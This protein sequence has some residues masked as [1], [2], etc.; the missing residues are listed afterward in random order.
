MPS[1]SNPPLQQQQIPIPP[2]FDP[3]TVDMIRRVAP[4]TMTSIERLYSLRTAVQYIVRHNIPGDIVECGVWRGGMMMAAALTLREMRA[5]DR[6][7][8]LYDTYEGMPPPT[9]ADVDHFG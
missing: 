6:K 9:D 7:L 2:D 1:V 3:A 5:V 8:W 4:F